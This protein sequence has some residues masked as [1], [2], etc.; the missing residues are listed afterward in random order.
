MLPKDVEL[1]VY[2]YIHR[3]KTKRM[4]KEYNRSFACFFDEDEQFFDSFTNSL[5]LMI[6]YRY[7]NSTD[8]YKHKHRWPIY[9]LCTKNKFDFNNRK[10]F[11]L[12]RNY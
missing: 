6:N 9:P 3:E 2:K 5:E 12:P 7:L 8:F 11:N 1:I 4:N 10:P